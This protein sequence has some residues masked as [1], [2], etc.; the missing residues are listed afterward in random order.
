M[1]NREENGND[2]VTLPIPTQPQ[3]PSEDHLSLIMWV[4][5]IVLIIP[6]LLYA[7][8]AY[9][10]CGKDVTKE[11]VKKPKQGTKKVV[12]HKVQECQDA[13]MAV[14]RLV[15]MIYLRLVGILLVWLVINLSIPSLSRKMVLGSNLW[16]WSLLVVIISCSYRAISIASHLVLL[17][18]GKVHQ[19]GKNWDYYLLGLRRSVNWIVFS[20][21]LCLVWHFYFSS[22]HGLTE[23]SYTHVFFHV[24]MWTFLSF[25]LFTILWL[26]KNILLLKWKERVVYHRFSARILRAGFQLYFLALIIGGIYWNIFRPRENEGA[27]V[28]DQQETTSEEHSLD[29]GAEDERKKK[30]RE[31]G[32]TAM[33]ILMLSPRARTTY[34]IK[35]MAEYFVSLAKESSID[36]KRISINK[37]IKLLRQKYNRLAQNQNQ[38]MTTNDLRQFNMS[39][40]EAGLLFKELRG[41]QSQVAYADIEKWLK[42]AHRNCHTLGLTLRDAKQAVECLDHLITGFTIVVVI[43]VWL[44]LSRI[45]IIKI[46]V[47]MSPFLSATIIFGD[48]CKRIFDG[49]MFAFVMHP[50]DV[51]DR[52][53]IDGIE[54][55][56]KRMN[57]L[58]TTF[59]KMDT[60]DEIVYPTS[61]LATK[62]IENL[63]GFPDP[64]DH[65]ELSLDCSTAMSKI[66]ELKSRIKR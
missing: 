52:C 30:E 17:F 12:Y 19:G 62:P 46:I 66:D 32:K 4:L 34:N 27:N 43:L 39:E 48:T 45:S 13:A 40:H 35:C 14:A 38:Y 23:A 55:E 36:G 51:G 3:P 44:L 10:I 61:V 37:D 5:L 64:S 24:G 20:S 60:N 2:E 22:R 16:K 11:K 25:L 56:V 41:D 21:A 28:D 57:I 53:I 7:L 26:I 1:E 33:S 9:V 42:M 18:L 63:K 49:I 65:L 58:S 29:Y 8:V 54:L 31:R 15:S 59:L 47:A 50:F 6:F